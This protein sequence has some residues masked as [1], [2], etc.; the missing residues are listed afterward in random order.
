MVQTVCN[1]LIVS[2]CLAAAVYLAVS[3]IRF[4]KKIRRID[5]AGNKK[6]KEWERFRLGR[7]YRETFGIA[8]GVFLF[9]IAAVV[10]VLSD[11]YPNELEGDGLKVPLL[12]GLS[13]FLLLFVGISVFFNAVARRNGVLAENRWLKLLRARSRFLEADAAATGAVIAISFL[14]IMSLTFMTVVFWRFL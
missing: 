11:T 12:I 14:G 9:L 1:F 2:D 6:G 10:L 4:P 7:F 8:E 13:V 5:P 3:L